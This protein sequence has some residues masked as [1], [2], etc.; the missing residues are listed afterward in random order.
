MLQVMPRVSRIRWQSSLAYPRP[1]GEGAAHVGRRRVS[2]CNIELSCAPRNS[3]QPVL[4][5]AR[6]DARAWSGSLIGKSGGAIT[7]D[8]VE[9]LRRNQAVARLVGEA[10]AFLKVIAQLPALANADVPVLITGETGCGKEL[11]ARA[12][13]YLG[14]RASFPFVAVNCGALPD[15]LVEDQLFGHESGAFTDAR[16]RRAGLASQADR[17]RS[18]STKR[19]A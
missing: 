11:I 9:R 10:P 6:R 18:S 2:M 5:S 14:T 17:G 19:T 8:L 13:H 3:T 1:L 16:V 12:I 15:A 4:V 7:P